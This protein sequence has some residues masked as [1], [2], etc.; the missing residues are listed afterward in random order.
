MIF[1]T[2]RHWSRY[3]GLS[4]GV[5]SALE[6]VHGSDFDRLDDGR[7]HLDGD[8]LFA[9]VSRYRTRTREMAVWESHRK[10]IDVQ[11]VVRGVERLGY[12]PLSRSPGIQTE[13]NGERDVM[14]HAPGTDTL[15]FSEGD[16]AILYPED[17]HAP[18]LASDLVTPSDVLK[19]VVKVACE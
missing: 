8:L 9:M 4:A 17:V 12:V 16:F 13:Y 6:Y 1:D 11:F 2:I 19:V 15:L 5:K 18:G 7:Y 3:T 10:Y 14:F